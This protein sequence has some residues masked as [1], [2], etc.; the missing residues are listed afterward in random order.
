MSRLAGGPP[1]GRPPSRFGLRQLAEALAAIHGVTP[2]THDL[3]HLPPGG[4]ER[5]AG[6]RVTA[7]LDQELRDD[8]LAVA[9]FD[10]L[11]GALPRMA[12]LRPVLI[13]GDFWPG[14]TVWSRDRLSGVVDWPG[15]AV[16]DP[17]TDVSQCRL[18]LSLMYGAPAADA[19]LREYG[20]ATGSRLGHLWV[21]DLHQ[22]LSCLRWLRHWVAGYRDLGLAGA[23]EVA[24]RGR[25]ESFVRRALAEV[26]R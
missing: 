22:A 18:D 12:W 11:A 19:F 20:A 8:P 5:R 26:G 9:A 25:L 6:E 13:H 10:A 21:V 2:E 3:S 17:R 4:V 7:G 15:A 23:T 14:N 16:G 1:G 24:L